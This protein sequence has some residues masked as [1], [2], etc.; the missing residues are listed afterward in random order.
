[1]GSVVVVEIETMDARH[2]MD[3][4]EVAASV[5]ACYGCVGR[6][7]KPG[8]RGNGEGALAAPDDRF[9]RE[10]SL[11]GKQG[12]HARAE[13]QRVARDNVGLP[14]GIVA[15]V[16]EHGTQVARLVS[17]VVPTTTVS[18]QA[19]SGFGAMRR[20]SVGNGDFLRNK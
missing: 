16:G 17:I 15:F 3:L 7:G 12:I 11:F 8:T 19:P 2:Q 1:M 9:G 5:G 18:A 13:R 6:C 14:V 4:E 10:G 20:H